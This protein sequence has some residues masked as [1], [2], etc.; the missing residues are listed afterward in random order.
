[1]AALQTLPGLGRRGV[2]AAGF[3]TILALL[4]A[5]VGAVLLLR[6]EAV[7][8]AEENAADVVH[9]LAAQLNRSVRSIDIVV[10]DVVR[11]LSGRMA[12]GADLA[13]QA[14]HDELRDRAAVLPEVQEL[15][16][17]DQDGIRRSH[18]R[19]YPLV[20]ES[21]AD[22][23]YFPLHRDRRA[24]GLY[25]GAPVTGRLNPGTQLTY[26]R[27]IEDRSGRFLGAVSAAVR[28]DSDHA[29]YRSLRLGPGG[30]VSIFRADGLMLSTHPVSDEAIGRSFAGDALFTNALPKAASGIAH[31]PGM[32]E[33]DFRILAYQRLQDY[34]IVVAISSPERYV[35]AQWRTS[36]LQI[37][38]G[39]VAVSAL[40]ALAI[41]L[42][43]RQMRDSAALGEALQESAARLGGIV[44]SAMDAIITIDANQ[45]IALFNRAAERVFGV[46]SAEAIGGPL[47]RFI[48]PRFRES[49]HAHVE[50]FARTGV[51]SRTMGERLEL[52]GLR[53]DGTEFPID[54]SI[55][56]MDSS[57]GK[58]LTVILRDVS[59]RKAAENELRR[60]SEERRAASERLEGIIRS[61]MDAL[62]TVDRNQRIIVFNE[63]AERIFRCSAADAIGTALGRF[64]PERF[65]SA[66]R[67]HIERFGE[68]SVTARAMG[69][70][71][72][73][74]GLRADGEE[75]PIDASISQATVGG[76][77]LYT[78]I[79]RDISARKAAEDALRRSHEELREMSAAMNEVREAERT[80]IAREL[81]DELGQLLTA[82]KMDIAWLA[83]RLEPGNTALVQR[84]EKMRQLVDATVAAV[85]RISADL[86]PVMLDDL[87]LVPALEHLLHDFSERTRIAASLDASSA[88]VELG[89]PLSTS[90]YRVV[91][92]ALTNVARHAEATEVGLTVKLEADSLYVR[93]RDNGKGLPKQLGENRS[94]GLLGIRERAQTL[95]GRAQIYSPPEGGTTV[96]IAVPIARYR[97]TRSKDAA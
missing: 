83:A 77:K 74:F 33:G 96:E 72:E 63:A 36:A 86:R 14:I 75:F 37:G 6:A 69:A 8:R 66:H 67:A 47:E 43:L 73:L 51:T 88:E 4:A 79:L 25:I 78:V 3:C 11:D 50:Q 13:G 97:A 81:H 16:L 24:E 65:R 68:T 55:S 10:A 44:G 9:V 5:A 52:Y 59:A 53:A 19:T 54:A 17:L 94:F 60:A 20:P 85:R 61:A 46:S 70:Q 84:S 7:A 71:I 42:V 38:I 18:S 40:V 15:V 23:D 32:I 21:Y 92:E 39:A 87:G 57:G 41:A 30:R 48:P 22:R 89:E 82:V 90:V 12:A 1:M 91:Q 64:I 56:Q 2:I 45:R 76:E 26:S 29:I 34:P 31:R 93:V 80:R 49:H 27:R 28:I 62:I 95:G 58:L 35:L